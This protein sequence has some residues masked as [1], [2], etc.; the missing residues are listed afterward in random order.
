MTVEWET[1]LEVVFVSAMRCGDVCTFAGQLWSSCSPL[2]EV[3]GLGESILS[4]EPN[5]FVWQLTNG[6]FNSSLN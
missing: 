6:M 4:N 3:A 2:K 5:N 1:D